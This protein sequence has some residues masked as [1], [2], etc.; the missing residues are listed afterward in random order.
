MNRLTKCCKT[1]V[2]TQKWYPSPQFSQNVSPHEI[3]EEEEKELNDWG[4]VSSSDTN[5]DSVEHKIVEDKKIFYP[6]YGWFHY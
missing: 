1:Y 2:K 6:F 5:F 4:T 3:A